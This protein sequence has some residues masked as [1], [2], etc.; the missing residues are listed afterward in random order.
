MKENDRWERDPINCAECD[1]VNARTPRVEKRLWQRSQAAEHI[2]VE[3]A[4]IVTESWKETDGEPLD[5][6]RAKLFRAIMEKNPI[7]I[8]EDELIVGSQ[9]KYL[10]GASPCVDYNPHV[11]YEALQSVE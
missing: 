2:A 11:A 5:I 7:V 9:S 10:V 3:R 1:S 8:H 4:V 6:R